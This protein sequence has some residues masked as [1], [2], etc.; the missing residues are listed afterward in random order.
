MIFIRILIFFLN[1]C[2]IFDIYADKTN[3]LNSYYYLLSIDNEDDIYD[4]YENFNRKIFLFNTTLDKIILKPL[5]LSYRKITNIYIR[6]RVHC[7]LENINTPITVIN[8][9]LQLNFINTMKSLWKFIINS[10]LGIG[11]IFN[12]SEKINGLS[13]LPQNFGDTLSHLG[14][15]S[16]PYILLPLYGGVSFRD[17]IDYIL[18]NIFIQPHINSY[19]I[20]LLVKSMHER[21]LALPFTDHIEKNTIDPYLATRI[22]IHQNRESKIRRNK[23]NANNYEY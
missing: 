20:F 13:V 17:T 4:P 19:Y 8:Y 22:I 9:S 2:T 6:D 7:F 11:G 3:T 16:G 15:K 10:T 1:L 18:N 12:I 21:N 14:I 23:F 5:S